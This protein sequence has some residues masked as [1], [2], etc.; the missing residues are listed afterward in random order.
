MSWAAESRALGSR[1]GPRKLGLEFELP[2]FDHDFELHARDA[3]LLFDL[4]LLDG[5]ELP[6][7]LRG[8]EARSLIRRLLKRADLLVQLFDGARLARGRTCDRGLVLRSL[9]AGGGFDRLLW[10]SK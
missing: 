1:R 10:P 4:G 6:Q 2:V 3:H 8:L 7:M 9:G 5:K